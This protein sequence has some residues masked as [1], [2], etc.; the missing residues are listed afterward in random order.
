MKE[1]LERSSSVAHTRIALLMRWLGLLRELLSVV[2]QALWD[3]F[4]AEFADRPLNEGTVRVWVKQ[5][6]QE[7]V[8]RKKENKDMEITA[9]ESKKRG[10]PLLLGDELD[11]RVQ[12]YVSSLR[13]H[14]AVI[15]TRIVIAADEG[16]VRSYDSSLLRDV[17]LV[18][19][20]LFTLHGLRQTHCSRQLRPGC[21]KIVRGPYRFMNIFKK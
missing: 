4:S 3:I 14:G 7:L 9:L 17:L 8:L 18:G 21:R 1:V 19:K 16:I 10:R 20:A 5:Y 12:L 13:D 11:K 2:L 6:K 15:N